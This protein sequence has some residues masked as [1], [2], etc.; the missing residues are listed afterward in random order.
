MNQILNHAID[1]LDHGYCIIPSLRSTKHPPFAWK[2]FQTRKPEL[3]ELESWFINQPDWNLAVV[4]GKIS[5]VVVV[6]ADNEESSR[7]CRLHLEPT[8]MRVKTAKGMHFYFAHPGFK[9]Q[10][11]ARIHS[12]LAIDVRADGG[13]ATGIGSLHH[14]GITYQLDHDCDLM[15]PS[16]LPPYNP[17]WFPIPTPKKISVP[18]LPSNLP[19]LERATRYMNVVQGVGA[20]TR[21]QQAFRLAAVLTRDF[22]IDLGNSMLLLSTWNQR[23]DP[24]LPEDELLA[25]TKSALSYK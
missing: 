21:N 17:E 1:Y 25:I 22:S 6:D 19:L 15:S 5:R 7:W 13:L 8:P 14:S 24:P 11:K 16:E 9:V 23:N 12:N 10:S 4:C 18:L 2:E 20:G 3:T